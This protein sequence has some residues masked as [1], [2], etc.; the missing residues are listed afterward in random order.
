VRPLLTLDP[1]PSL[2]SPLIRGW[3]TLPDL[4][5]PPPSGGRPALPGG[6]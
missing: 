3:G 1:L 5:P 4:G 6:G 2:Q